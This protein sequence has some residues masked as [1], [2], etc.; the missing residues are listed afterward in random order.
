MTSE[1]ALKELLRTGVFVTPLVTVR[2][3]PYA[4]EKE[5]GIKYGNR[6]LSCRQYVESDD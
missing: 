4:G 1:E 2:V 5:G 3:K 6:Q